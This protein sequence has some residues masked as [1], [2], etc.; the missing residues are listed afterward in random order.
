MT[1]AFKAL[2]LSEGILH[3]IREAGFEKPSEIQEKAIPLALAGEDILGGSATGSG[4]TLAFGAS[5]I[6]KGE[7]GTGIKALILTPTRELAEQVAESLRYFS[8]FKRLEIASIYGGVSIRPQV[9]ALRRADVVVGTPGRILDHLRQ[10]TLRLDGVKTLVLD[11][12]DRMLDMGFIRDVEMII[13]KCPDKRQTMLFSATISPDIAHLSRKYMH[14]PKEVSVESYVDPAKLKQVY[15]DVPRE[16][17]FSLLVHLLKAEKTGLVMVFCNTRRNT[18]FVARNLKSTG[19]HA[20]AIHGGLTQQRRSGILEQFHEGEVYVLVCTDVAARGLDIGGVSHVYNYDLP[21]TSK[22]Y[23]HRIGR[24]ARAGKEGIAINLV[25]DR[26]HENFRAV[27][28]NPDLAIENVPL[29]EVERVAFRTSDTGSS[30]Y[31][32]GGRRYGGRGDRDSRSGRISFGRSSGGYGGG[33][34]GR[35]DSG[36]RYG[37]SSSGGSSGGGGQYS[38][39]GGGFRGRRG[40]GQRSSFGGQARRY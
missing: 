20:L 14:N 16:I 12:A 6:E 11:E 32:G 8:R 2:G 29:P 7:R 19:I 31:G 24:T 23:V 25:S 1:E 38:R 21:K 3:G 10:G 36:R 35:R 9:D 37:S 34:G 28:R 26:D 30:S 39:E 40:S 4:K 15:Y 33:R 18:D 5:I 17:K 13:H 27:L 22:D